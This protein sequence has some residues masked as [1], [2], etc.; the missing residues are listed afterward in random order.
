MIA[1]TKNDTAIL[2]ILV[3]RDDLRVCIVILYRTAYTI[4]MRHVTLGVVLLMYAGFVWWFIIGV[5]AAGRSIEITGQSM[6][7]PSDVPVAIVR[8]DGVQRGLVVPTWRWLEREHHWV[9]VSATQGIDPSW[10]PE[11]AELT[12]T[13]GAWLTGERIQPE[14]QETLARL[15]GAA[16]EAG[17]PL[18][19]ISAYRSAEE[20]RA[21]YQGTIAQ[22]GPIYA[23][24][25]VALPGQ[26]EHQLGLAIDL[27]DATPA[28]IY[29]ATCALNPAAAT[30]LETHAPTYGFIVRYPAGKAHITGIAHEPWHFRYVGEAMARF[31]NESGLTYDEI[32]RRLEQERP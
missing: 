18:A 30:W 28:C 6:A 2:I 16:E 25:Y 7:Q 29:H 13:H 4:D 15:F 26:S 11:L 31:V 21:L 22:Q 12:V 3:R 20:Q 5:A 32:M 27:A 8:F 10:R 24:E 17:M 1:T 23:A 19:V 9:Y 14:A